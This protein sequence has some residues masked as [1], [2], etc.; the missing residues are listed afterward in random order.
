VFTPGLDPSRYIQTLPNVKG[1]T[2]LH[3]AVERKHKQIVSYLLFDAKIE[4]NKL[5]EENE[6]AALHIAV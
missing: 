3:L 2:Y 4:P 5:T 6:M 1:R